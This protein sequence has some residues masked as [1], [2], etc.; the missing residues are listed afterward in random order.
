M[1]Q[2]ARVCHFRVIRGLR[3]MLANSMIAKMDSNGSWVARWQSIERTMAFIM[4][5][6][7]SRLTMDGWVGA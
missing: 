4:H 7:L 1:L 2:L 6:V 3:A 5:P